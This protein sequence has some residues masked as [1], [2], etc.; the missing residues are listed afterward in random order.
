MRLL[1]ALVFLFLTAFVSCKKNDTFIPLKKVVAYNDII[2][3]LPP[4]L[5]AVKTSISDV[6]GGFY[7]ALPYRYYETNK[8]YPLLIFVHGGGQIGNG[9]IDLP[10]VLNDGVPRLLAAKTFPPNF[11]VDGKNYSFIILAPQF[12]RYPSNEEVNV[13]IKYAKKFFRVDT[14]RIYMSGLS[15]GGIITSDI[16]AQHT[17][18]LAA[19]VPMAGVFSGS[20]IN[21][22]CQRIATGNLPVWA[23]HNSKDPSIDP[24]NSQNFVEGINIFSPAIAARLTMFDTYGHDA[25]TQAIDPAYKENGINIYEWMLQYS[26]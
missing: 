25:W 20:D 15:M 21:S 22:K 24:K 12:K 3:T 6:I 7:S 4:V 18:S 13:F 14:T 5:K 8:N 11:Q 16:G 17:L 2:E 19:I 23:F 26:R 9:N 1:P 10:L